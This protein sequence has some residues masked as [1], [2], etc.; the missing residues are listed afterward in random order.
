MNAESREWN[1]GIPFEPGGLGRQISEEMQQCIQNCQQCHST[2]LETISYCLEK[3]GKHAETGH[4]RLLMSCAEICQTSADF[5][6][7]GSDLHPRVCGV[8]ADVCEQCAASCGN[9]GD[10]KQM[11]ACADICRRC[12]QTCRKMSGMA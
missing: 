6:L 5:M 4:I 10:D 3:G 11:Q 7:I 12:A 2:C 9:F 8:C 1:R